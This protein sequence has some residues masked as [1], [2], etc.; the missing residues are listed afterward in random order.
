MPR[1]VSRLPNPIGVMKFIL[2]A[3]TIENVSSLEER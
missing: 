3:S 2:R 1:K